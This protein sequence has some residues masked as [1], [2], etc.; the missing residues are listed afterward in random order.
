[1]KTTKTLPILAVS[2]VAWMTSGPTLRAADPPLYANYQ[3]DDSQTAPAP[4][5]AVPGE[6]AQ[7][8]GDCSCN[9]TAVGEAYCDGYCGDTATSADYG[10]PHH[11]VLHR[12]ASGSRHPGHAAYRPNGVAAGLHY[13][14]YVHGQSEHHPWFDLYARADYIAQQRASVRSWHAGYYHTQ[15]GAPLALM[16]PPTARMQT[17]WGW[18]VSQSTM[19][20]IY[21]Q[22]ERPYPGPVGSGMPG[23]GTGSGLLPTPRW[24]SHTDQFGVYYVR[25]PW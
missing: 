14:M 11:R 16:V 24:P 15:Y 25:G 3:S 7:P 13:G 23:S 21:H 19:S 22:F 10:R 5:Q 20:P 4:L 8:M 9:E 17:R 2:I 6:T 12:M 18:G 1:M